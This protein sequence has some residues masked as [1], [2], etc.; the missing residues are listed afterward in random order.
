MLL[1]KAKVK[2]TSYLTPLDA[3]NFQ[4]QRQAQP[5]ANLLKK[6]T[7]LAGALGATKS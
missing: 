6:S 7:S 1:A 4:K 5:E 2:V 3:S